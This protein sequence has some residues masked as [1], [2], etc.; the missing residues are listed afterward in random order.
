[1]GAGYA[2]LREAIV[3][4][5]RFA[6]CELPLRGNYA[7]FRFAS[8]G[9]KTIHAPRELPGFPASGKTEKQAG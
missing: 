8:T 1:R 9:I 6:R 5:P 2:S 3:N 7:R 4:A